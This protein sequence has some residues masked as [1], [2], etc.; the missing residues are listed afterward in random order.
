M[1]TYGHLACE[2]TKPNKANYLAPKPAWG[3]AVKRKKNPRR[4]PGIRKFLF[5]AFYLVLNL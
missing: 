4:L 2:K 5:S 3:V 1:R